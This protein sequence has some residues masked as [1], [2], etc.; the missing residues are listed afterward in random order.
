ME[1]IKETFFGL[2]CCRARFCKW[3]KQM[4]YLGLRFSGCEFC[5]MFFSLIFSVYIVLPH[6][7]VPGFSH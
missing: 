1:T 3:D 4:V 5:C 6:K 7:S 2:L